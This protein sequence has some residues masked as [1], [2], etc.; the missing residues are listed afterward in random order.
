M[1]VNGQ[2]VK[3]IRASTDRWTDGQT[4]P[5]VLSPSF[6]VDNKISSTSLSLFARPPDLYVYI[7]MTENP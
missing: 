5:N 7:L 3:K 6:A 4:P 1:K 2:T